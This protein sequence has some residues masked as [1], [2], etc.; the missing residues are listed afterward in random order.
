MKKRAALLLLTLT[1]ALAGCGK[2]QTEPSA[3]TTTAVETATAETTTEEATTEP[4]STIE[5][6]TEPAVEDITPE[7]VTVRVGSL[8]GPTSMGLVSLMDQ[9][10]KGEAGNQY[11][12]TM[13]TA[14]DELLGK[15]VSN[16]MDIALVPANVAS[17]L[18]NKTDGGIAVININTLGVLY[19]VSS[20]D[21]IQS[22][23][24]LKGKTLYLTGK[25][26]TPEYVTNYLL[27]ANGLTTDDVTLEFKSEATEVAAILK[28]QPDAIGLLPQPFVTV[29]CAQNE[30]LKIVLDCTKEWDAAQGAGGSRLVTGVTIVRKDFQDQNPNAVA[31]FLQEHF[32]SADFANTNVA[33]AA[34]L[35]ANQGIIEKAPIAQKAI[36]YCNITC[37]TG[38]DMKT[39]LNGYLQVLADQD[40]ASIGGQLPGNDFYFAP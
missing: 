36:P 12:F 39:A 37:I 34:E 27:S 28:E 35:V 9:A 23:A 38:D 40:P 24:D 11:D 3:D 6:F 30:D 13:V 14:A 19:V 5:A 20:D 7:D 4:E 32:A 16:E 18:Y 10:E 21:S 22:F 1:V 26:T 15:I 17:V 33:D 2:S 25:G 29:A 8:K 31:L